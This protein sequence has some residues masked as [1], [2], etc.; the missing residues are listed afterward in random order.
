MRTPAR[1]AT[2][3]AV[4]AGSACVG[5]ATL[6]DR[7]FDHFSRAGQVQ[8]ALIVG[9]LE[10]ARRPATWLAEH[11]DVGGF[12]DVGRTWVPR[13][14]AA[15]RD[16][17]TAASL[18]EAAD[19]A[20][21]VGG[22]CAGCHAA[23]GHGPTFRSASGAPPARTR[24]QHMIGHLWAMDR[25]WEGLIGGS[26]ETWRSGARAIADIEPEPGFPGGGTSAVLARAV[27]DQ[28]ER[29]ERAARDERPAA[30]A[31]M[32]KTCAACHT[33]SGVGR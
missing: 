9:D 2:A 7:M 29:A 27:H 14:Q 6:G 15:A 11:E 30:Y 32:V 19:A 3:L 4:S 21:R 33:L 5:S 31:E 12:G 16:V 10:G 23:T 20:G 26:D 13:M 28:A 25:M 1:I 24:G 8:T 22:T 17:V 18:D